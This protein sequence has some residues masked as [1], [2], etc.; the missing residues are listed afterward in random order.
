MNIIT[1][2][3]IFQ[4]W[5]ATWK[6]VYTYSQRCRVKFCG[7][8]VV[9]FTWIYNNLFFLCWVEFVSPFREK[10]SNEPKWNIVIPFI[11]SR[12][13]QGPRKGN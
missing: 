6:A 13:K 7:A 2:E 8:Y 4:S 1:S 3:L 12:G 11:M 5:F 10:S 9:D